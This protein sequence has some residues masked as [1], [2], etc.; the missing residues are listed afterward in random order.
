[1]ESGST[2]WDLWLQYPYVHIGSNVIINLDGKFMHKTTFSMC[3]FDVLL[4]LWLLLS[5][6]TVIISCYCSGMSGPVLCPLMVKHKAHS[7]A[8]KTIK[9]KYVEFEPS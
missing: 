8:Y 9:R 6:L 7:N 4:L 3:V 5:K 2:S 1:M